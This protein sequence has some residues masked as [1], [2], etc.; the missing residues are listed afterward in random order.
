[1]RGASDPCQFIFN[2]FRCSFSF[3][4]DASGGRAM[5][6]GAGVPPA[7]LQPVAMRKIAARTPAP[8]KTRVLCG[9]N[10]LLFAGRDCG[11]KYSA[12]SPG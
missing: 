2:I 12:E 4:L 3:E 7:F 1:M 10:G 5:H 6:R 9:L 8:R 11:E